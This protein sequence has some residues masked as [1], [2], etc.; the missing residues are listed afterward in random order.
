[1]KDVDL[2][3]GII[4]TYSKDHITGK[5]NVHK[6]Q[7]VSPFLDANQTER[8]SDSGNWKGE[9]HKVASIPPILIEMWTEELKAKGASNPYPLAPENKAFLIAKINS[10]EFSKLRTKAGRI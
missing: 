9:W 3:T 7:D 6:Q 4:E 1:M 10:T 5:I 2:Q 8:N